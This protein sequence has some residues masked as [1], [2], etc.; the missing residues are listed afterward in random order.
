MDVSTHGRVLAWS[1]DLVMAS[2]LDDFEAAI[3]WQHERMQSYR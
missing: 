2:H 3:W 1:L